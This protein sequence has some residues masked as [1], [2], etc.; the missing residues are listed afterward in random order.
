MIYKGKNFCRSK[1]SK[2]IPVSGD[3]FEKCN[4][5]RSVPHT[6]IFKN[7]SGLT[8]NGCNL[9]N[10]DLPSGAVR[11]G[12]LHFHKDLCSHIHKNRLLLGEIGECEE[13][14][15][16]VVG[17]DTITIDGVLVD[18]IYHYEDTVVD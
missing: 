17:T 8:F 12:G 9:F 4:F 6:E 13:S 16:H 1:I 10:C 18:T 7:I 2:V 15:S 14:C 11:T 3:V 5:S